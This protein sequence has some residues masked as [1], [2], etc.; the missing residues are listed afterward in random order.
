LR[1]WQAG[2]AISSRFWILTPYAGM[3]YFRAKL[4]IQE[5]AESSSLNYRNQKNIGYYYGIT[6]NITSKFLI[7]FER[8]V[9]DE[10]AYMVSSQAVF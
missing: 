4:H 3:K 10:F 1:E 2:A 6:M 7:T 9:V 8:R 5:G